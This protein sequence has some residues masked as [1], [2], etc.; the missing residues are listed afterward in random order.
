M[1]LGTNP[2]PPPTMFRG[3]SFCMIMH[4]NSGG[5]LLAGPELA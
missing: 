3:A 4:R 2:K 5:R 1:N